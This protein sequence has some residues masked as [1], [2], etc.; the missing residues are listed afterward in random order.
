MGSAKLIRDA[1]SGNENRRMG[2]SDPQ[3]MDFRAIVQ[4]RLIALN[5]VANDQGDIVD[6]SGNVIVAADDNTSGGTPAE[7][8][9]LGYT[10]DQIAIASGSVQ[11]NV[12]ATGSSTG[13]APAAPSASGAAASP[14]SLL[15][16]LGSLFSSI[17]TTATNLTRAASSTTINPAT[18][19]KYGINPATG[20]PYPAVTAQNTSSLLIVGAVILAAWFFLAKRGGGA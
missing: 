14:T 1:V 18:G 9:S 8:L 4:R 3:R 20:L 15:S 5:Y 19:V 7:L 17:G 11:S 13:A 10:P 6:A 2:S 12:Y 16:G